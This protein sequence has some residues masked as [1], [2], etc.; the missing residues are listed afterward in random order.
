MCNLN[1]DQECQHAAEAE[2]QIII[3]A[4]IKNWEGYN[5]LV[6]LDAVIELIESLKK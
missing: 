4:I 6:H 5:G 3:D 2:Q 1:H